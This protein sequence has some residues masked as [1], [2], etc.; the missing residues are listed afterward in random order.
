MYD[1][2]NKLLKV[3]Q[4]L[5]SEIITWANVQGTLPK[6]EKVGNISYPKENIERLKKA[7]EIIKKAIEELSKVE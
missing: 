7:K 6:E 1:I 2:E 5:N 3:I 4:E